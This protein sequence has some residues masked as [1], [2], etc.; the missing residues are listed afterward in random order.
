MTLPHS[1]L[2]YTEGSSVHCHGPELTTMQET[3]AL[4]DERF[5][6]YSTRDW[7]SI[8]NPT[9]SQRMV[10]TREVK[11]I[12]LVGWRTAQLTEDKTTFLPVK[13]NLS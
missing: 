4:S 11:I 5:A 9:C 7:N 2:S 8:L 10:Q 13:K 12:V 6:L 1:I 3:T